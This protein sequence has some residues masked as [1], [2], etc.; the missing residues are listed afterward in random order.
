M[1][2]STIGNDLETDFFTTTGTDAPVI[3][4][5]E[6]AREFPEIIAS[7]GAKFWLR[8]CLSLLVLVIF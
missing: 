5:L 8:F 4:F 6:D 1:L 7:T 3:I 2:F